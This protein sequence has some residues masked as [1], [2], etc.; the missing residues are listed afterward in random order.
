MIE[1]R[2]LF[3]G[4]NL[5]I[6]RDKFKGGD[7]YFDLIYLDPPFNSNRAYNVLFKEGKVD[8]S[9]QIHAFEDIWQ[10]TD[11]TIKLFEELKQYG[12]PEIAILISSLYEFIHDTPMMAYL[13][14]MTARLIPLKRVL[15]PTGSIY[16]HCDPTASHY[17]K[18]IMDVIFSPKNFRNEIIWFYKTGGVSKN[19]F[20]RKHDVILFYTNDST[21]FFK[22]QIEKS[23]L[24]HKYGF[25]DIVIK[26]DKGGYYTEVGMRD[27]WD[28]P[29]LRGN[30]PE[31][32]GYPTQK[33]E[34]VLE[35]ILHAS[36]KEGDW[37]LDPF[38]GC[39]TTVAV[40]E[41][42]RRN[43][44]GIDISMQSIN[45]IA[46]RMEAHY[47]NIELHLHGIPKDFEGAVS[48]AADDKFAF[49]DWAITLVGANPPQGEPRKGADRGVDG[50]ILFKE[51]ASFDNKNP[52]LNKIIVQVKG[53]GH[54]RHDVAT[55]KGDMGTEGAPMGIFICLNEPTPEMKRV[56]NLAGQYKFSDAVSFPKIQILSIKDW[57]NGKQVLV[58]STKINPFR[59]AE[60]RADQSSLL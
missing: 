56:A 26:E 1:N 59:T 3:F 57:F 54:G 27:V 42:L 15:K 13:V 58:P 50:L 8:S 28:I 51:Q 36:T 16:L 25:K 48:L 31:A 30:Q 38:C 37:V 34:A 9:A 53:G 10:W 46:Q 29:A 60:A 39:G 22:Q 45:V 17:L 40:A 43:W 11:Y 52:K 33:P 19:W 41:R 21:Y 5:E 32:L 20:G 12:N 7:G 23:Y 44:V 6:L 4:D 47:P 18:I 55:L 14:N 49:Q 35:R 2:T 24:S